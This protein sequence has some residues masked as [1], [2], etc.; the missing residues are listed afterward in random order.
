VAEK[1]A[2]TPSEK[3]PK[4]PPHRDHLGQRAR[5]EVALNGSASIPF[6][7]LLACNLGYPY[8]DRHDDILRWWGRPVL[9][10][11]LEHWGL[12]MLPVRKDDTVLVVVPAEEPRP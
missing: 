11:W 5:Q 9:E 7:A 1:V 12:Y 3:L 10:A 2:P 4:P 6:E 8:V